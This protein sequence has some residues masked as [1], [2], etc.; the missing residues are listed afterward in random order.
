MAGR[1]GSRQSHP[2]EGKEMKMEQM[3]KR[4]TKSITLSGDAANNF[5]QALM[6]ESR[7]EEPLLKDFFALGDYEGLKEKI[8]LAIS[9]LD[10]GA[11]TTG[12]QILKGLI[13]ESKEGAKSGFDSRRFRKGV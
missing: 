13:Y 4:K 9:C 2:R 7:G 6:R 3:P 5:V 11:V 10:D 8:E 1:L 12:T